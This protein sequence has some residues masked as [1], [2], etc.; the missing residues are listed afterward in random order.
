MNSRR[1]V[2]ISK[3]DLAYVSSKKESKKK[4]L[5]LIAPPPEL[6]VELLMVVDEVSDAELVSSAEVF[7]LFAFSLS[8]EVELSVSAA[9]GESSSRVV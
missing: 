9:P 8:A 5:M 1:R 7:T 2:G 3:L 4:K 6:S